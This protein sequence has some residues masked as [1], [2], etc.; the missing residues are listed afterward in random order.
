MLQADQSDV[1]GT[2]TSAHIVN[3]VAPPLALPITVAIPQRGQGG[4]HITGVGESIAWDGGQPLPLTGTGSLDLGPAVVDIDPGGATWHLDGATRLLTPGRYTAGSS[5]A[6]G[7]SGLARPEDQATFTVPPGSHGSMVTVGDARVHLT[8][9]AMALTGPG[10]MTLTGT[11]TVR[12]AHGSRVVH[13][14]TFGP[15]PFELSVTPGSSSATVNGLLQGS[16]S[17]NV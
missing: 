16:L 17:P 9:R 15:G 13:Q 1:T 3:A 6:V 14:V 10:N 8:P 2:I 4:L 11:L 5:V 12:T 7:G